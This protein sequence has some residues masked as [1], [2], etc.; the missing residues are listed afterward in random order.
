MKNFS[1]NTGKRIMEYTISESFKIT[2]NES[3]L[4]KVSFCRSIHKHLK[5]TDC[6]GISALVTI[7]D[8]VTLLTYYYQDNKK[9]EVVQKKIVLNMK[10][11][12]L[13]KKIVFTKLIYD[14]KTKM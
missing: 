9:V 2:S 1:I 11:T 6:L 3:M 7:E 10:L 13:A 12:E 8:F 4:N 5:N 14:Q